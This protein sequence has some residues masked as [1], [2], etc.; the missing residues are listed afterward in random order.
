MVQNKEI[1]SFPGE[2]SR[3]GKSP[4][5]ANSRRWQRDSLR[6]GQPAMTSG[7][8]ESPAQTNQDQ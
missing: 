6:K 7:C 3:K 8:N 4:Q 5:S 2:E 1:V